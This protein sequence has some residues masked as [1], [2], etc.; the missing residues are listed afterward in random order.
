MDQG[1]VA[2]PDELQQ[3]INSITNDDAA[4]AGGSAD[5]VSQVESSVAAAMTEPAVAAPEPVAAAPAEVAPIV[6]IDSMKAQYG[7][8]DLDKVKT[9]ALSDLRPILEKVDIPAE[10]KFMIYK[11]ILELTEDKA[12]IEPAYNAAR[13]IADEKAKGEALIFIVEYIDKLGIQMAVGGE[14]EE[15]EEQ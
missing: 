13:D 4:T 9:M 2:T 1:N 11:D 3:A 14:E 10:K 7:D 8:P 15:E 5:V 12:C 6:P